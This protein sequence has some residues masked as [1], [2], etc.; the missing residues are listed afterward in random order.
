MVENVEEI[1]TKLAQLLKDNKFNFD[2]GKYVRRYTPTIIVKVLFLKNQKHLLL[3]VKN[4]NDAMEVK[5]LITEVIE[6][7][8]N[9]YLDLFHISLEG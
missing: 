4:S 2:Y 3:F 6:Q 8:I 1:T 7:N 5:I 9:K